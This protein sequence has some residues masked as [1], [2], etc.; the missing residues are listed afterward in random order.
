MPAYNVIAATLRSTLKWQPLW[1]WRGAARWGHNWQTWRWM[2]PD[3]WALVCMQTRGRSLW[4]VSTDQVWLSDESGR[5]ETF[6]RWV[7]KSCR[8]LSFFVSIGRACFERGYFRVALW[9]WVRVGCPKADKGKRNQ[10]SMH[11]ESVCCRGVLLPLIDSQ[12][13]WANNRT[14]KNWNL[15]KLPRQHRSPP[16]WPL[17]LDH[18]LE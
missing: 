10:K 15:V 7:Q 4:S 8:T 18:Q 2:D 9:C 5:K 12:W 16:G 1:R 14:R 11:T 3:G 13:K 17:P 6:W